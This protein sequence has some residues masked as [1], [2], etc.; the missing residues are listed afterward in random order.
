M[1]DNADPKFIDKRT[2]ERYARSGQLDEKAYERY[3]KSLPDVAEKAALVET[4]MADLDEEED[5]FDE[6]G[7]EGEEQPDEGGGASE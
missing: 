4:R 7:E 5:E 2:W 6:E 3:L 1:A